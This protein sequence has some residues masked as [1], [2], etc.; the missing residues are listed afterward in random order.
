MGEGSPFV[1]DYAT[2][3]LGV[4]SEDENLAMEKTNTFQT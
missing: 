2:I 4:L 3:A 1:T